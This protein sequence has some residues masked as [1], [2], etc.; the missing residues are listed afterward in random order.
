MYGNIK[1]ISGTASPQL[2]QKI[3]RYLGEELGGRD[4]IEFPN[5]NLFVQLHASVRGQDVY[6]I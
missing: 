5:G 3:S 1:L 2:A 4:I 6:V